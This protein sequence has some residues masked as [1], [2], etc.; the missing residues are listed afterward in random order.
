AGAVAIAAC[1]GHGGARA[2]A[3]RAAACR[4]GDRVVRITS[5]GAQRTA[6]VHVPRRGAGTRR[7][8]LLA[9][10]YAGADG[11][12]MEALSGFS[13]SADR[14][15]F[16]VAYPD[17]LPRSRPFWNATASPA[18]PDDVAFAR[19]L[20]ARLAAEGCVDPD[21]VSATGVSSGASM[22]AL[23]GC[24][25]HLTGIA[26]VAGSYT[27]VTACP[28]APPLDV[29]EVH[30]TGDTVAPYGGRPGRSASV[31]EFLA[32]W[33]ATDGCTA[34]PRRRGERTDWPCAHDTRVA[35]LKLRGAGH[36]LPPNPPIQGR[37]SK[38]DVPKA[39]TSFLFR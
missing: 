7:P 15:G 31:P 1:G 20:I 17:A 34:P 16:V 6:R 3:P 25:L 28:G 12:I 36:G 11:R 26:P 14:R 5:A 21:R 39:I 32:G 10:H 38:T 2:D 4:A 13:R 18:K 29:L 24:R 37:R 33:R 23:L 35:Q 19:D 27:R 9:L 30:G 8:L 22:V